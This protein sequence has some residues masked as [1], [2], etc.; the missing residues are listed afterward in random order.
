[1][2]KESNAGMDYILECR[3]SLELVDS[4]FRPGMPSG[5]HG[6]LER[7]EKNGADSISAAEAARA[8]GAKLGPGIFA[9]GIL[10]APRKGEC[11]RN[12]MCSG[13]ESRRHHSWGRSS[14]VER[15]FLSGI[16]NADSL[17]LPTAGFSKMPAKADL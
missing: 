3:S 7:V 17:C 13:F 2:K 4:V 11:G 14:M 12:Y 16:G 6:V 5:L 9:P 1:M 15:C 8:A 10:T